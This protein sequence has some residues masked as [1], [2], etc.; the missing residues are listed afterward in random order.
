MLISVQAYLEHSF[1]KGFFKV[2]LFLRKVLIQQKLRD[3]ANNNKKV[4]IWQ[5]LRNTA[6]NHESSHDNI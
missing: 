1:C 6:N 5:K 4:L 2:I 3:T